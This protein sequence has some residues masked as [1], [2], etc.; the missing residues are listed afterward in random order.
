MRRDALE[1]RTTWQDTLLEVLQ[2]PPRDEPVL[3]TERTGWHWSIL[4]VPL[5][6]VPRAFAPWL[7]L[8]PPL[9]SEVREQPRG[10]LLVGEG[11]LGDDPD[12]ALATF[13]GT[14]PVVRVPAAWDPVLVTEEGPVA[15]A[16]APA[17]MATREGAD[18]IVPLAGE[19]GVEVHVGP[20]TLTLR[21]IQVADRVPAAPF[22]ADRMGRATAVLTV[23]A[24]AFMGWATT[25]P[26]PAETV[27]NLPDERG[28]QKVFLKPP[29]PPPPPPVERT[30]SKADPGAGPGGGPSH[31]RRRRGGG[32]DGASITQGLADMLTA[33]ISTGVPTDIAVAVGRVQRM[34]SEVGTTSLAGRRLGHGGTADDGPGWEDGVPGGWVG[35]SGVPGGPPGLGDGKEIREPKVTASDPTLIGALP[36]HLVDAVVKRHLGALRHCWQR[37]LQA[38]PTLEGKVVTKFTIARDG[39]VARA[40]VAQSTMGDTDVERCIVGRFQRMQFPEPKGGG[41]VIVKYPLAFGRR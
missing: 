18:W 7:R 3:L 38:D 8:S 9:M 27:L 2:V 10:D 40:D 17:T 5:G 23:M 41:I 28:F 4:G 15:M 29:P 20:R 30:V 37:R 33:G 11:D 19:H 16:E 12:H 21:R 13:T 26:R 31:V 36:A 22:D 1:I 32:D 39:S 34:G 24:L 6:F 25:L 14:V 35:G